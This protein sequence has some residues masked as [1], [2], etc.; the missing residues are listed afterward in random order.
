MGDASQG[1]RERYR[2]KDKLSRAQSM[3]KVL[4][5]QEDRRVKSS[6]G[7]MHKRVA[8]GQNESDYW[9]PSPVMH[10]GVFHS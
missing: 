2:M 9:L 4:D 6:K 8:G 10:T 7:K 5:K 3:A 1:Q